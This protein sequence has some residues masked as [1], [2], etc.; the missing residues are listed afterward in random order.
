MMYSIARTKQQH[1]HVTCKRKHCKEFKKLWGTNQLPFM[2]H[3]L[4]LKPFVTVLLKET[5]EVSVPFPVSV[6]AA[7]W[8]NMSLNEVQ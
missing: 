8:L 7:G 4:G 6:Y 3:A 2:T 1:S 5:S